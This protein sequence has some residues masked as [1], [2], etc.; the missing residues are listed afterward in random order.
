M[1][2][3]EAIRRANDMRPNAI[4][5]NDK[6]AFLYELEGEFAEMMGVPMPVNHF[7]LEE[8]DP[9]LLMPYPKDRCYELYL[10]AMIDHWQMDMDLY[11]ADITL[12]NA[13]VEDAKAWWRRYHRPARVRNWRTM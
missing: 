3:K 7:D 11:N 12:A 8:D 4:S 6:A 9:E 5:D 2:L 10:C 13:A 1:K